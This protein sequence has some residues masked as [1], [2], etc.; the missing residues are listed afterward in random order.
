MD[1]ELGERLE[2][3]IKRIQELQEKDIKLKLVQALSRA[4]QIEVHP[5]VSLEEFT[6]ILE[7]RLTKLFVKIETLE[8]NKD[9]MEKE[10]RV[11][12]GRLKEIAMENAQLITNYEQ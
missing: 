8:E 4:T 2:S 6:S 10:R 11:L 12:N 7:E 5:D 1:R 3:E 9:L